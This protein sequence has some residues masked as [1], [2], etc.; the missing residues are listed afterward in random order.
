MLPVV[1][2]DVDNESYRLLTEQ[3][4]AS[5]A[6]TQTECRIEMRTDQLR[7][8]QSAVRRA[9]GGVFLL[10]TVVEGATEEARSGGL[11]LGQQAMDQNRDNYALFITRDRQSMEDVLCLCLR[12]AGVMA[13]PLEKSRVAGV[14]R[15]ILADYRRLYDR[16]A[17]GRYIVCHLGGSLFSLSLDEILYAQAL[18]KKTELCT[19]KQS[20]QIYKTMA[21][22]QEMLGARFLRCHRSYLVNRD[23]IRQVVVSEMAVYMQ[24][25]A[26]IP[27]SRSC[28]DNVQAALMSEGA[29]CG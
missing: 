16:Q 25:G 18:D 8:A 5:A 26:R 21:E 10:I 22:M 19:E 4:R 23:R 7:E 6:E 28:K 9:A 15:K 13:V 11:R 12:P 2:Y 3:L 24:D 17:D 20:V 1:V 27:L 14:L 29:C